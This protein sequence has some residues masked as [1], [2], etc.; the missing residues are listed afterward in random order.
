MISR[1]L[2]C[3]VLRIEAQVVM[4]ELPRAGCVGTRC[5][6]DDYGAEVSTILHVTGRGRAKA[7]A[8]FKRLLTCDT[9]SAIQCVCIQLR[10]RPTN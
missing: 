2:G 3:V 1:R 7:R 4:Q 8:S 5:P 10:G 9:S 6:L